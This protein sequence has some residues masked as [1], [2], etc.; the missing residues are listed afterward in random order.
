MVA[1]TPSF[2]LRLHADDVVTRL[3]IG[4]MG[5]GVCVGG[6]LVD[7]SGLIDDLQNLAEDAGLVILAIDSRAGR[8]CAVRERPT[9]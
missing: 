5:N 9:R 4:V 1:V 2:R 7:V 8:R 3:L 6:L